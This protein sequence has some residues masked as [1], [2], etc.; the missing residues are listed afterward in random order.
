MCGVACSLFR[1]RLDATVPT[2]TF[3]RA[4]VTPMLMRVRAPVI[5][6]WAVQIQRIGDASGTLQALRVRFE[7]I[8]VRYVCNSN[9]KRRLPPST[10]HWT[11]TRTHSHTQ[12]LWL[13]AAERQSLV[14]VPPTTPPGQVW[15]P[16]SRGPVST[17]RERYERV[18]HGGDP[19]DHGHAG[20][21]GG[22]HCKPVRG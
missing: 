5:V 1:A 3:V 15:R 20:L 10:F 7:R 21:E 22:A 19:A 6:C 13:F 11:R 18:P 2:D 17:P 9:G 8:R 12:L 14:F 16:C 4:L